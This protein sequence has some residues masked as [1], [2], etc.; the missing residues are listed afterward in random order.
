M[1]H[2]ILID[3]TPDGAREPKTTTDRMEVPGGHMIRTRVYGQGANHNLPASV[4][5]VFVPTSD[6]SI[7]DVPLGED[8]A[9][10]AS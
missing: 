6:A 5:M 4:A 2:W 8:A 1:N 3:E 9:H 7:Y 10:L